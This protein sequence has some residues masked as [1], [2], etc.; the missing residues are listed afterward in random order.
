MSKIK[1]K[2]RVT[3]SYQKNSQ[4]LELL[5]LALWV[6]G[7]EVAHVTTVSGGPGRQNFRLGKDSQPG[8]R[9]PIPE[10]RYK[11]T[12]VYWA[13]GAGNFS[14]SWGPGL[15]AVV[16]DIVNAP[17]NNTKRAELRIHQ[18]ENEDDAPGTSGC[19]GT[20][21]ETGPQ[22]Y[23]RMKKVLKWL[24]DYDVE[25]LEVDYNLGTIEKPEAEPKPRPVVKTE[26]EVHRVK[27]SKPAGA[28]PI[29]YRDGV[30]QPAISA[31]LDVHDNKLGLALNGVQLPAEQIVS[32]SIEVAYKAGK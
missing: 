32:V 16:I 15:G 1:G 12:G 6:K 17:G 22:D 20:Q 21:G 2:L 28:A 26:P 27:I 31:R 14:A 7:E 23:G 29:V 13:G 25:D 5:R 19:L 3:R 4:G 24:D 11:L 10:G 30:T 9:E 8:S 18:D